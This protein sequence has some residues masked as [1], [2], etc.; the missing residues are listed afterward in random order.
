[1][2]SRSLEGSR[3]L[4]ESLWVA[5]ARGS[6]GFLAGHLLASDTPGPE[7]PGLPLGAGWSAEAGLDALTGWCGFR[8]TAAARVEIGS[9]LLVQ[10]EPRLAEAV[11]RAARARGV[12]PAI[13]A[14]GFDRAVLVGSSV[15]DLAGVLGRC[16]KGGVVVVAAA[17][18][19][20]PDLNLYPDI[21]RRGVELR[22]LRLDAADLDAWL[23]YR[24]RFR[25]RA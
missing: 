1:M 16:R 20:V 24:D 5:V 15:R 12:F 17:S 21:H 3:R 11:S 2:T 23:D 7:A 25:D 19:V 9:R 8:L 4:A 13:E 10:A 14:T 18:G 22:S 6:E